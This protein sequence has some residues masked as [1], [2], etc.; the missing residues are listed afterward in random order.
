MS[1]RYVIHIRFI[2]FTVVTEMKSKRCE[3]P[4]IRAHQ[5][6]SPP[7][8]SSP[9]EGQIDGPALD[10]LGP[11]LPFLDRGSL[12]LV[13]RGALALRLE[14]MQSFCLPKEALRDITSLL[15]HEDLLG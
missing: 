8:V 7:Q 4:L 10:T 3:I 6:I 14:E 2:V 5:L 13:D 1:D 12:A 11:L 9:A 15:T